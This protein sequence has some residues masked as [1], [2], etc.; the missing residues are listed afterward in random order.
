MVFFVFRVL[1]LDWKSILIF[2]RYRFVQM[3]KCTDGKWIDRRSIGVDNRSTS[4]P[5]NCKVRKHLLQGVLKKW[6]L[7]INVRGTGQ[8]YAVST[9]IPEICRWRF[10]IVESFVRSRFWHW[11]IGMIDVPRIHCEIAV[12]YRSR[13]AVS[14][15]RGRAKKKKTSCF[16]RNTLDSNALKIPS[17]SFRSKIC[18]N[19]RSCDNVRLNFHK[20]F[21]SYA[22]NIVDISIFP[23]G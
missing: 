1:Y 18:I 8:D 16:Q 5:A 22:T 23:H 17:I 15:Q 9:E 14:T 10:R 20:L 12:A 3:E 13:R 6:H 21:G 2:K 11:R 7:S 19:R 4:K